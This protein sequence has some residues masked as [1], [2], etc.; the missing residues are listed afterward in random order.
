MDTYDVDQ[1]AM[2]QFKV[3]VSQMFPRG[4]TRYI[5]REKLTLLSQ[6]LSQLLRQI[7]LSTERRDVVASVTGQQ[8]LELLNANHPNGHFELKW[9]E[10]L[11]TSAYQKQADYDANELI[12]YIERWLS[13]YPKRHLL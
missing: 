9:L 12:E 2:T 7:L 3:G 8:W 5:Q 11:S 10:L 4:D 6:Q 13:T 1:E